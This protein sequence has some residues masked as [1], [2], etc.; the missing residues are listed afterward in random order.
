MIKTNQ[1]DMCGKE[2]TLCSAIRTKHKE[3][4]KRGHLD[5]HKLHHYC[6][7]CWHTKPVVINENYIKPPKSQSTAG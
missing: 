4:G 6:H 1:C 3:M 7:N 2:I 5:E